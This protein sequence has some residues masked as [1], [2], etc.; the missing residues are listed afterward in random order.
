MKDKTER[1]GSFNLF[2]VDVTVFSLGLNGIEINLIK[3][4]PVVVKS[5]PTAA[6]AGLLKPI[7]A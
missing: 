1:F 5:T 7:K 6:A 2:Q 3:K 4:T